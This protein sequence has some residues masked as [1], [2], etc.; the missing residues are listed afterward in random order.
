MKNNKLFVNKLF[1]STSFAFVF[2]MAMVIGIPQARAES[3]NILISEDLAVG[4]TGPAVAMLQS[5]MSE[6]GYLNVP[7]NIPF[8]YYGSLTQG[9]VTR[10]QL[11]MNVVPANGFFGQPAKVAMRQDFSTHGW[12][13]MLGW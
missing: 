3:P 11:A 8:G 9:A 10:Y 4:S 6:L 12:L 7:N 13:T 1:I 5:I 2:A